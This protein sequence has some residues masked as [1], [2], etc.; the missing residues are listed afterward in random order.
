MIEFDS[1]QARTEFHTLPL[2]AQ[3][4]WNE[5]AAR[6]F[7]DGYVICIYSI[8]EVNGELDATVGIYKKFEN[9]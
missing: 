8:I 3:R 1:E 7:V 2:D 4:R 9:L 5:I 6:W